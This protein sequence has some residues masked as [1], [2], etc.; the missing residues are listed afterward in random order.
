[1]TS[2]HKNNVANNVLSFIDTRTVRGRREGAR[3]FLKDRLGNASSLYRKDLR[4]HFGCVNAI[5]FSHN[6][7]EWISSGVPLFSKTFV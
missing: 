6:G 5:E 3:T 7:G 2:G 1:M 4:S